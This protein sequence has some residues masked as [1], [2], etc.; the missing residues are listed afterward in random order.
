VFPIQAE[1]KFVVGL[2]E[3]CQPTCCTS[4]DLPM[5]GGPRTLK[6]CQIAASIILRTGSLYVNLIFEDLQVESSAK[7]RPFRSC[8]VS[9][10][11]EVSWELCLRLTVGLPRSI[12]I[13]LSRLLLPRNKHRNSVAFTKV[14]FVSF[15]F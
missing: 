15:V 7:S 3:I 4:T 13:T 1:K 8:D 11:L 5:H 2:R 10:S 12:R 14:P 6:S 9:G